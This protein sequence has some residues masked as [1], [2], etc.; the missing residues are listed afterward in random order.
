[1]ELSVDLIGTE[2]SDIIGDE[3]LVNVKGVVEGFVVT[4]AGVDLVIALGEASP[5]VSELS[6]TE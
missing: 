5:R 1:M 4:A 3:K 6:L 2:G